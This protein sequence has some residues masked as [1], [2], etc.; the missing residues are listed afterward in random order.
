MFFVW[1][2][3]IN[4]SYLSYF[5]N[6]RAQKRLS[7]STGHYLSCGRPLQTQVCVW[8][9]PPSSAAC[10]PLAG[11]RTPPVYGPPS[12]HS[13]RLPKWK[14]TQRQN[15]MRS[16]TLFLQHCRYY[17]TTFTPNSGQSGQGGIPHMIKL[18]I[19]QIMPYF[20]QSHSFNYNVISS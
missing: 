1:N 18:H 11:S 14:H 10:C 12:L 8:Q 17:S 2:C 7:N 19:H 4:I 16:I 20:Y 6:R 3:I 13:P 9:T 5:R 15:E